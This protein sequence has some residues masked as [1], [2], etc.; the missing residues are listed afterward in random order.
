MRSLRFLT[1]STENIMM[2]LALEEAIQLNLEQGQG[3]NTWRFW[4]PRTPAI[5]LGA[6]QVAAQEVHLSAAA[7]EGVPILRRHSGGGAVLISAGTIHFSATYLIEELEGGHAIR[8]TM[9]AVLKPIIKVLQAWGIFSGEAGLSD[10]VVHSME[11]PRKI[12]GNAQAR[13]RKTVLVHGTLLANPNWEQMNRL[14]PLPSSMPAY[15]MERPHQAF[16]TSLLREGI[17]ANV[18]SFRNGMAKYLN[19]PIFE[20]QEPTLPE[21]DLARQLYTEKYS[22]K[23]WNLRR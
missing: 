3:H 5:I 17:S 15:R 2:D 18:D 9:S 11:G 13:K 22:L 10:L 14:L 6:G 23:T 16:L 12:A 8:S 1:F 21:M 7:D 19:V 20:T 4:Q